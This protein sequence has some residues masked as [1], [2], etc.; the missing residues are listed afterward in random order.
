MDFKSR[1]KGRTAFMGKEGHI[2]VVLQ[3]ANPIPKNENSS[4]NVIPDSSNS[5]IR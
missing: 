4:I 1:F 2:G 5:L 3:T